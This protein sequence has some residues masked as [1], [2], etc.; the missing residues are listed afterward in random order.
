MNRSRIQHGPNR[1][2]GLCTYMSTMLIKGKYTPFQSPCNSALW[3]RYDFIPDRDPAF[4][5]I[6]SP[7]LALK[8]TGSRARIQIF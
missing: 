4:E 3:I 2:P 8:G 5:I 7:G 6:P 1:E